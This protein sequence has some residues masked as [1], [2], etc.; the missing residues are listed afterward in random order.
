MSLQSIAEEYRK[1][2]V[3]ISPLFYTRWSSR[4]MNGEKMTKEE[5]LPLFEA[6]RWSPS[7][8]NEQ[9]WRFVVALEEEEKK[10]FL[11]LM[12]EFNQKWSK[13]AGA[14]VLILSKKNFTHNST[15]NR[16]HTFDA[17]AAWMALSLEG[18]RRGYIVHGIA[19]FD[20]DKTRQ[21]LRI[22][23]EYNIEAMCAIGKYAEGAELS[24]DLAEREKPSQRKELQE[25]ISWGEFKG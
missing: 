6:A 4:A 13:T 16:C 17:G 1:P 14:I 2:T 23:E 10:K 20:Y 9:P 19:G 5:L 8:F 15:P 12:M 18:A 11:G 21:E 25:L 24:P 7:S 22:P 3:P